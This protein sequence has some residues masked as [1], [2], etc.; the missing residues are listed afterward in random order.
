MEKI[1]ER[2]EGGKKGGLS[3]N[4]KVYMRTTSVKRS[5]AILKT[6]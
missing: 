6:M 3:D 4:E 2:R 1:G 5:K